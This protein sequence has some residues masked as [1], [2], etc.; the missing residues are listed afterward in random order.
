MLFRS[1]A[2]A[3]TVTPTTAVVSY[4]TKMQLIFVPTATNTGASTVNISGLGV[5]N[6]KAVDGTDPIAG[7]LMSGSVYKAIY[8]GT[9]FRLV[10]STK[11][12]VDTLRTYVNTLAFQS[13]LPLIS[14]ATAGMYVSN[15]GTTGLWRQAV[16]NDLYS[17]YNFGGF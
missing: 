17:Y 9:E 4:D 16:G 14:S 10:S 5:K 3:Y 2:N 1:A 11:Q 12:Y 6:I 13:A 8:N 15:N 7:D